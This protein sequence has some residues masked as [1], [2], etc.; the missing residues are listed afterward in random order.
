LSRSRFDHL[1]PPRGQGD[2]PPR[3]AGEELAAAKFTPQV[4]GKEN[5]SGARGEAPPPP[6]GGTMGCGNG[7]GCG[8]SAGV[9]RATTFRAA[10]RQRTR[11]VNQ[12]SGHGHAYWIPT[13]LPRPIGEIS[14]AIRT[15]INTVLNLPQ[16]ESLRRR[17]KRAAAD[18]GSSIVLQIDHLRAAD[19]HV[20]HLAVRRGA[21]VGIVGAK[22]CGRSHLL[23]CIAGV[24][25][26]DSGSVSFRGCDV[27]RWR[28]SARARLGMSPLLEQGGPA[29]V[30]GL[31]D[32]R[33]V[34]A[35]SDA[36]LCLDD[37]RVV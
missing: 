24:R 27:T 2:R 13:P 12:L 31:D 10:V 37:G 9:L 3:R 17:W 7:A 8:A 35:L 32:V 22:Q 6:A 16:A 23:D 20:P 1:A 4:G 5:I 36:V 18:D 15:T 25:R 11:G 28:S 21:T 33:L 29:V 19:V 34:L 14:T 30:L 26:I